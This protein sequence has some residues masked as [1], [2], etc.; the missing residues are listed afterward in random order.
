MLFRDARDFSTRLCREVVLHRFRVEHYGLATQ[1]ALCQA[2]GYVRAASKLHYT[3][4][5][6]KVRV[7]LCNLIAC[8]VL[9]LSA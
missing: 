7:I 2:A 1:Y 6:R 5:L 3:I 4:S 8:V 9:L